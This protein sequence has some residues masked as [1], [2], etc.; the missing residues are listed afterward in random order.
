MQHPKNMYSIVYCP[1]SQASRKIENVFRFNYI[2]DCVVFYPMFFLE[3]IVD[4][5]MIFATLRLS[6]NYIVLVFVISAKL[7]CMPVSRHLLR[8]L[9]SV[10]YRY[11]VCIS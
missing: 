3:K 5:F 6:S 7:K 2:V 1:Q 9:Y 8:A 11:I 4:L 10:Q